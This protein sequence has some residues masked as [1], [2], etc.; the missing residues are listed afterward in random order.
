LVPSPPQFAKLVKGIAGE[1]ALTPPPASA[2][3]ERRPGLVS[4]RMSAGAK[5]Q[6]T[7][8]FRRS[9]ICPRLIEKNRL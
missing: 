6:Y 1:L 4:E 8:I 5:N 9:G 3:P 2:V 7:D